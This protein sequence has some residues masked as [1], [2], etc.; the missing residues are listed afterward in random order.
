M[1]ARGFTEGRCSGH[2]GGNLL[3][4]HSLGTH[5][6]GELRIWCYV[7]PGTIPC[8]SPVLLVLWDSPWCMSAC[9]IIHRRQYRVQAGAPALGRRAG[10]HFTKSQGKCT[11]RS[12]S[13]SLSSC[14]QISM[15]GN[16]Q[17]DVIAGNQLNGKDLRLSI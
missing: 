16:R 3:K 13:C 5:Y 7:S 10:F 12:P 2:G 11:N 15:R 4:P 6:R 9:G 8:S 17:L 1:V 14:I